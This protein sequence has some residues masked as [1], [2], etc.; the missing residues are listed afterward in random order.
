[1]GKLHHVINE[2]RNQLI[3]KLKN[4]L[5]LHKISELVLNTINNLTADDSNKNLTN[6]IRRTFEHVSIAANLIGDDVEGFLTNKLNFQA[7]NIPNDTQ[8]G[9]SNDVLAEKLFGLVVNN[10]FNQIRKSIIKIN[11]EQA[12]LIENFAKALQKFKEVLKKDSKNK[13]QITIQINTTIN[14][15]LKDAYP[16][17]GADLINTIDELDINKIKNIFHGCA[18]TLVQMIVQC[19]LFSRQVVEELDNES[20]LAETILSKVANALLITDKKT[21]S[22]NNYAQ[23]AKETL[24]EYARITPSKNASKMNAMLP[25]LLEK[26]QNLEKQF[27]AVRSWLTQNANK[28]LKLVFDELVE[29][30]AQKIAFDKSRLDKIEASSP[31]IVETKPKI[32][33]ETIG[34]FNRSDEVAGKRV[35]ELLKILAPHLEAIVEHFTDNNDK[36]ADSMAFFKERLTYFAETKR[37]AGEIDP[38][39]LVKLYQANYL[40]RTKEFNDELNQLSQEGKKLAP[41]MGNS[42]CS[43]G[44]SIINFNRFSVA[45]LTLPTLDLTKRKASAGAGSEM[46]PRDA[47]SLQS[48]REEKNLSTSVS[49]RV[50]DIEL[51]SISSPKK[52]TNFLKRTFSNAAALLPN[53][54]RSNSNAPLKKSNSSKTAQV[55]V[56]NTN[57]LPPDG[58]AHV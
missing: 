38:I 44:K 46:S 16:N 52:V 4:L 17:G 3:I 58:R 42:T 24:Y 45:P 37:L 28:D 6:E 32:P 8:A 50:I 31:H 54:S 33:T 27:E 53:K 48:P 20:N 36:K 2:R 18:M 11:I 55:D 43:S 34:D 12:E 19:E 51:S 10:G 1:M 15:M 56:P 13:K 29:A 5:T 40:K 35:D 7:I 9:D 41:E 14:N 21:V 39:Q 57:Q 25:S 22:F 23:R 30:W 26:I 49:P 47:S